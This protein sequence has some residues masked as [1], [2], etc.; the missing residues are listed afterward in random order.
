VQKGEKVNKLRVLVLVL[1]FWLA[2][3]A[4]TAIL[5][6]AEPA[7]NQ[8]EDYQPTWTAGHTS[9]SDLSHEEKQKR[10]GY[11]VPD[12]YHQWWESL[13]KLEAPKGATTFDPVFD[14]RTH[15]GPNG[16]NGVTPVKDQASCGSCWAFAAV[17]ELESMVKIYGEVEL[18]LSEQQCV[19]CL[20]P[21][22]GCDGYYSE[23]CFDLFRTKGA[24]KEECM[25]YKAIDTEPCVQNQCQKWA[26]LSGY[27][28]IS[29]N[30]NSIK[31][32]LLNGPVKSG[33]AVE[34][35]FFS[36]TGGC[37]N[38]PYFETN[39][40]VVIVGWDDT[41]CGGQGAWIVKNSW[42]PGFGVNGYY[43]IKYG[44]CMIGSDAT[45]V[46][47]VF[48]RP[49]VR[50]MS[51]GI[52]DQ[53]GGDGDGRAEAGETV[54]LDFALKNLWSA[55]GNVRVTVSADTAG[56]VINDNLSI[57]GN[58]ASKDIKSN[59]LDPM[60]FQVPADFPPRWI[61]FTFHVSG[62]SGAGVT[63][64]AD[65]TVSVLVG[66]DILLVDD[67]QGSDSLGT[68]CEGYYTGIFDSLKSV[69]DTWNRSAGPDT[70]DLSD[71]QVVVWYTGDHR[72]SLFSP[73]DMEKLTSYLD[74]GGRLFLTSQDAAEVL[75]ASSDPLDTL[76]L[77]NYLHVGYG[78][79]N[80][81]HF[82]SGEPGDVVGDTL[83]IYPEHTPGA[84]N[85]SS[86]DNLIPDSLAD[87]VLFYADNNFGPTDSVA[88]IKYQGDYK[89][90]FFGFGF[91]GINQGGD[92][93]HGE[94]LSQPVLV[95]DR[96]LGWLKTPWGYKSGDANGDQT[97]D[98]GDVVFLVNYLFKSGITPSYLSSGDA[99]GDCLVNVG[100]IVYLINYLFKSGTAP[101]PGCA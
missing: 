42:G 55:L 4:V 47:Y 14:W 89:L 37:Y 46:N 88:A 65:T 90:V 57:L 74:N 54:R 70:F 73:G 97:V 12:W 13:P 92:Y 18:D 2:T 31:Q 58:M 99:N 69:Y 41:M 8:A 71:Y 98:V 15:L 50:L 28:A 48:H 78:G 25:P 67:D 21:N 66:R 17:G 61:Y 53:A 44:C 75:S 23:A 94:W 30:V 93:F 11:K 79:Y 9:V 68:N 24:I 45:Q 19:S 56:L 40:A 51:Y 62:D 72:T 76:F 33:M 43:Y 1:C 38:K 96:V 39:H 85:Q 26:K 100:D 82:V 34:D 10:L 35:T 86:K 64:R 7:K 80:P 3:T 63:Y 77:R 84:N 101:K 59:A 6:A 91:E 52:N 49:L 27:I 83:W 5:L 22:S 29:N 16:T 20:T 60:Q 36:Y 87:V 95:M 81:R 32:A